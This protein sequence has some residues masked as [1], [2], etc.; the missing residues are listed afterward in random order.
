MCWRREVVASMRG[1]LDGGLVRRHQQRRTRLLLPHRH[2]GADKVSFENAYWIP[3]LLP[4]ATSDGPDLVPNV[5][6]ITISDQVSDTVPDPS[7]A[8]S[9]G[10]PYALP[11]T[12]PNSAPH[13]TGLDLKVRKRNKI[14][15]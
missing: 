1:V 6:S 11:H 10:L 13:S 3:K 5:L 12:L 9:V 4:D 14:L 15:L 8:I 2:G 7:H